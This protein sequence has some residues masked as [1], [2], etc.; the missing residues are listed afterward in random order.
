LG[1]KFLEDGFDIEHGRSVNGIQAI[2]DQFAAFPADKP[3]D[4]TADEIGTTIPSL[5]ENADFG[6]CGVVAR[7]SRAEHRFSIG[8]F[9]EVEHNFK[10]RMRVDA[11]ET[12]GWHMVFEMNLGLDF[13]PVVVDGFMS[14]IVDN[15]NGFYS[16]IHESLIYQ[17]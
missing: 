3:D 15:G 11:I 14:R 17:V 6:E 8:D 4:G 5:S 7:V 13:A 16:D 9:V 10:M 1:Q 12:V 2:Y